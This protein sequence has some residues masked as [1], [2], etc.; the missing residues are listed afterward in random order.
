[1]MDT[2]MLWMLNIGYLAYLAAYAVRDIFWLRLLTIAG[3]FA[4]IPYF[5]SND[6]MSPVYWASTYII[7]NVI[8]LVLLIY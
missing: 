5:V 7:I 1:M 6:T 4:T 8:N 2:V 3:G